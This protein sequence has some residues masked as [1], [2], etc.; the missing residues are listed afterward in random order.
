VSLQQES[1]AQ[2]WLRER[3]VLRV[4]L[5]EEKL[6]LYLRVVQQA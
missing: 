2:W 5:Q 3:E 6:L 1:L 4:L